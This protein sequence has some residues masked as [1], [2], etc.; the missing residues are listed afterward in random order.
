MSQD[1]EE[2]AL[3]ALAA[4]TTTGS[5]IC[6]P[7]QPQ[8]PSI[9]PLEIKREDCATVE[10][11]G[12][13]A[14]NPNDDSRV[15][16]VLV[17]DLDAPFET[18]ALQNVPSSFRSSSTFSQSTE[19]LMGSQV[20][21][22]S[23]H[24]PATRYSGEAG[25][26]ADAQAAELA[27]QYTS[28]ANSI[29]SEHQPDV[30]MLQQ[31]LYKDRCHKNNISFRQSWRF[32]AVRC[33]VGACAVLLLNSSVAVVAALRWPRKQ[34]VFTL[35]EG[36]CDVVNNWSTYLHLLINL[37]S[38]LLLASSNCTMQRLAAPTKAEVDA[39][40]AKGC[41]LD[42]GAP[43]MRNILS[44]RVSKRRILA[45]WLICLTSL[46]IH[47]FYNSVLFKTAATIGD[48]DMYLASP[49][50]L[51]DRDATLYRRTRAIERNC[52]AQGI[53]KT[54]G[55]WNAVNSTFCDE[56]QSKDRYEGMD[57]D[58]W[59]AWGNIS[60][61]NTSTFFCP[62]TIWSSDQRFDPGAKNTSWACSTW[63]PDETSPQDPLTSYN[64]S[65]PTKKVNDN[66]ALKH[67]LRYR[68]RLESLTNDQ[69]ISAYSR[70]WLP[71][72][73]P[74]IL[75]TTDVDHQQ[76]IGW[77]ETFEAYTANDYDWL[78]PKASD[79]CDRSTLSSV[80]DRPD[81]WTIEGYTGKYLI[82][83]CLSVRITE[84]CTLQA[85]MHILLVVIIC[86]FIKVATMLWTLFMDKDLPLFTVGDAIAT[87]LCERPGKPRGS[88]TATDSPNQYGNRRQFA[89]VN[90]AQ[91][92]S[93][94]GFCGAV[95]S[96]GAGLL[97]HGASTVRGYDR[98]FVPPFQSKWSSIHQGAYRHILI[99]GPSRLQRVKYLLAV[100]LAV[101]IPQVAISLLYFG[102]NALATTILLSRE[103]CDY[104]IRKRPL[105]VSEPQGAQTSTYFLTLPYRYSLPLIL[106]ST[107]VHWL[108]SQGFFLVR[109][110]RLGF[111]RTTMELYEPE[112][113]NEEDDGVDSI[114]IL[115]WPP[116]LV[117]LLIILMIILAVISLGFWTLYGH[118]PIIG[119]NSLTI[120]AACQRP[121]DD[122]DAAY[123]PISWG[124]LEHKNSDDPCHCCFTSKE[125]HEP[126]FVQ[127][128][129]DLSPQTKKR[130]LLG[131]IFER[132]RTS[133][134]RREEEEVEMVDLPDVA[135][136]EDVSHRSPTTH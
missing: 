55:C 122:N 100:V 8:S 34:G 107:I 11:Q 51:D 63:R 119:S 41:S 129:K 78:C 83:G 105:R 10:T 12:S 66:F 87:F 67:F 21:D 13:G 114:A 42:I 37:L 56:L 9:L 125:V 64:C 68:D 134:S 117:A 98:D 91:W 101:N 110:V 2:A 118:M 116:M 47:L 97:V 120:A 48:Y 103:I 71:D 92:I 6:G 74:V 38:S 44:L 109:Y 130:K 123:L 19:S 72:R 14:D 25:S 62:I 121:D 136:E 73:G 126:C 96:C 17:P 76:D 43:S 88:Y 18:A 132:K 24:Q 75:W 106:V 7:S 60:F 70:A 39:S 102:I 32:A 135:S 53:S 29:H 15:S 65:D 61:N 84:R 90:K 127:E 30:S 23:E 45:W 69:C 111:N 85:S 33:I 93:T 22:I 124:E 128:R 95:L 4:E 112:H 99:P 52:S 20:F 36:D 113:Y 31:T 54:A 3:L 82:D 81:L 57:L 46:P 35:Y 80:K 59:R 131:A 86:N 89:A 5:D 77:I 133:T 104:Y 28:D 1:C 58:E 94:I 26:V 50:V 16:G 115:F 108:A 49:A 40:H 79:D 27:V